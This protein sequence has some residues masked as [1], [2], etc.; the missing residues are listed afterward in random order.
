VIDRPVHNPVGT[1]QRILRG[2]AV[3]AGISLATLAMAPAANAATDTPS[4]NVLKYA[5]SADIDTLNPFTSILS[6]G[7]Q[8]MKLEYESLVQFGAKDNSIVPGMAS[9]WS[10]SSD[11]LTWTYTFPSDR[12]WSDGKPVTA[13]DAAFT[14]SSILDN[15]DLQQSNGGEVG[16]LKSAK[17]KNDETLVLTLKAPQAANPGATVPIVPQHI[18]AKAGDMAKFANDK[19]VVGSGPFI[20]KSYAQGQTVQLV[21]NKNFWR[22]APKIDGITYVYYKS[23][24]AE[25]Q[26]LRTGE[27]DLVSDLEPAQYESLKGVKNIAVNAGAGRRHTALAINPGAKDATGAPLGNGNPA[28]QDETLRT[29]IVMAID[30]KTLLAK[31]AQGL[32]TLGQT[33]IPPVYPAYFGIDKSDAIPFDPAKANEMLDKAGYVK[34]ADGIRLDKTGKPL[35]LR[36]LG[37]ATDPKH[38]Q[39][40]EYVVPWLKDI[41]IAVTYT[42]ASSNQVNDDST[43]GKY[44]MY[45]TGWGVDPDPDSQLALNLCS[46][47]PNADG[48]GQTS[49]NNWCDPA[50]DKLYDEQ[51]TEL[52]ADKRAALVKDAMAVLSKSAANTVIWYIDSLEAYRSDRFTG[53]QTQPAKGGII[54]AQNGYWGFYS[55][56]PV[57]STTTA[58][59]DTPNTGLIVG[60]VIG[61]LV[62]A[63]IVVLLVL[64]RRRTTADDRE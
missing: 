2:A 27:V 29:A 44:D 40:A 62:I 7:S 22:G 35:D 39:M 18:W 34:G 33:E 64:R 45:F 25:V 58:S 17:A 12:K 47:M 15:P 61:V 50:F 52:N 11:G 20:V 37:R 19:D 8:I 43:L 5:T 36:L 30:K 56:T 10:T 46:S 42:S 55:A 51:H 32:G 6:S 38:T 23:G 54:T 28:L 26:A 53:F 9:K 63:G 14:Y 48:S 24:D 16:N 49:E 41:G 13:K 59:N 1:G 4:A 3:V 21:A 57:A 60:I 31:V